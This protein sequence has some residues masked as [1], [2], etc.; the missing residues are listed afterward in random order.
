MPK[1]K[2]LTKQPLVSIVTSTYNAGRYLEECIKTVLAQD[3]SHVEHIIQNGAST[4]NTQAIIEKY[5]AKYQDKIKWISEKDNGT[6][7]ATSRALKRASG[8]IILFFSADCI[9][10]PHVCSWAVDNMRKYHEAAVVYGDEYIIDENGQTIKTFIPGPYNFAK[11]VCNEL[12]LPTEASFV[13]RSA[14]EKVGFYL[15]GSLRHSA[16]YELWVRLGLKFPLRYVGGFVSKFRWHSR[17][18]TRSPNL[19]RYFVEDKK[20][21][22]TRLFNSQKAPKKI[23]SLK[24]QAYT[25]LYFWAASQQIASGAKYDA[26]RY[27]TKAL[28]LKSSWKKL[29]EY[30]SFWRQAV[31]DHQKQG[32]LVSIITAVDKGEGHIEE[33]IKSVLAQDYPNIEYII[34]NRSRKNSIRQIFKK[35][36]KPQYEHKIK[37]FSKDSRNQLGTLSRAIRKA[38]G[39]VILI[40]NPDEVLLPHAVMWGVKNMKRY[41]KSG[42]IYGGTQIIDEKGEIT[43]R[44]KTLEVTLEKQYGIESF[45]SSH[46]VFIRRSALEKVGFG[47]DAN[48][49]KSSDDKI[50]MRISQKIPAKHIFGVVTKYHPYKNQR[51][52]HATSKVSKKLVASKREIMDSLFNSAETPEEIKKMKGRAYASYD[53]WAS[54]VSFNLKQPKEGVYYLLRSF[55][56][57]PTFHTFLRVYQTFRMLSHFL[58]LRIKGSLAK[59]IQ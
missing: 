21:V 13:R 29:N 41:P 38:N 48:L 54:E 27:L 43:D 6:V 16:D 44:F 58:A 36:Q 32:P 31:R 57:R 8:D 3:Y 33:C 47:K 5:A 42:I 9:L 59:I 20:K 19:V 35:Y 10:L 12:I 52:V 51:T 11:L 46:T 17:S 26:I 14:F 4:D 28:L 23:K 37:I 45:S 7:E 34:Q 53:L 40:V 49:D 24:K 1:I 30:V 2:K 39:D 56:Q 15:D 50:W 55:L 18:H 22:M 25:G